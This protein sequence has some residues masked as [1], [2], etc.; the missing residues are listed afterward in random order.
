MVIGEENFFLESFNGFVSIFDS[1]PGALSVIY[2]C[3]LAALI[4]LLTVIIWQFYRTLAE[5]NIIKLNLKQYNRSE[6]PFLKKTFAVLLYLAEYIVIIPFFMLLWSIALAVALLL[7]AEKEIG[8]I[9]LLTAAMI[10]SI[11]ILAYY[12]KEIAKDLAKLFP[13]ITLSVFLINSKSLDIPFILGQIMQI[14]ALLE[15]IYSYFIV[16]FFVEVV[17]RLTDTVSELWKSEEER[18]YWITQN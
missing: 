18:T 15:S 12:K 5:R 7:L 3:L 8:Y 1:F 9:V 10:I 14:P 13:L 11:R 17:L 2:V 6:H 4:T 16:I